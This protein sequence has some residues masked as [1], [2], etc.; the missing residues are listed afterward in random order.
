MRLKPFLP[1]VVLAMLL[2]A[3]Q[4]DFHGDD[5]AATNDRSLRI[6]DAKAFFENHRPT[7]TRMQGN[8]V[9]L[10]ISEKCSP[11]WSKAKESENEHLYCVEVPLKSGFKFISTRKRKLGGKEIYLHQDVLRKLVVLKKKETNEIFMGVMSLVPKV[12]FTNGEPSTSY[13]FNHFG[14]KC[15]YAG[16]VIYTNPAGTLVATDFYLK[17]ER[18][19]HHHLSKENPRMDIAKKI[20]GPVQIYAFESKTRGETLSWD[21]NFC[22]HRH[23]YGDNLELC[24]CPCIGSNWNG[25]E[26][27]ICAGCLNYL[28]SCTCSWNNACLNCGNLVCNCLDHL[29]CSECG[30][31]YEYCICSSGCPD[32]GDP[33]CD[34]DHLAEN[35]QTPEPETPTDPVQAGRNRI[36]CTD[37]NIN[38]IL[39]NIM[40]TTLGRI[41]YGKITM[42]APIY[43]NQPHEGAR[44]VIVSGDHCYISI[45]NE[46]LPA[47]ILY[48]ILEELVHL[49]QLSEHGYS[50]FCS[51]KLNFEFEAKSI[52]LQEICGTDDG[53]YNQHLDETGMF[54]NLLHELAAYYY[55]YGYD[56]VGEQSFDQTYQTA[57]DRIR[58]TDSDYADEEK[59]PENSNYRNFNTFHE[60][61]KN[62]TTNH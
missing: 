47:N 4:T 27:G 32:C 38:T 3:C 58:N 26:D 57:I 46:G 28:T 9:S 17:G 22:G 40:D 12:Y 42:P 45:G 13:D 29:T 61:Y 34:I 10:G 14:D 54:T 44:L 60:E 62:N 41:V 59:Y 18:I 37:P 21:C 31:L 2:T 48:S 52:I 15:G 36:S 16:L 50:D 49:A 19:L 35:E 55:Y 7:M 56:A 43:V 24:T 33:Y 20:I 11:D 8:V 39:N 5:I 1:L 25:G 6:K 30:Q 53:V 23:S 51:A